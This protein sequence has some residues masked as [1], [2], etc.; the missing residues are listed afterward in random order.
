MDKRT[1]R[2]YLYHHGI[3]GQKWG[4][5]RFQNKDGSLTAEGKKRLD[6]LDEL[7]GRK[8]ER[9]L[10]AEFRAS[11]RK[12]AGVDNNTIKK[13]TEI[14]RYANKDETLDNR[15]KYVSVT[16]EDRRRYGE[17]YDMIGID[18]D[19]PFGE[20]TYTATHDLKIADADKVVDHVMKKYGD[21]KLKNMY[22]TVND[23]SGLQD[24]SYQYNKEYKDKDHVEIEKAGHY[25]AV[26]KKEVI[27]R[28]ND[29][30]TTN[31]S[32]IGKHF[33]KEGYDGF[34]DIEDYELF[35]TY[36]VI[37]STPVN[38]IELKSYEKHG[39]LD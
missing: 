26:A 32:D 4:V 24:Y 35:S 30:M 14:Y 36:P 39:W 12:R 7:S 34:V 37:L 19:K 23:Y 31:M 18:F 15:A 16:P 29:I 10:N 38:S 28:L 33:E 21:V 13:G 3:K 5:R 20:Y 11:E 22:K 25:V 8:E 1:N 6:D 9:P 27:S 17:A 2:S